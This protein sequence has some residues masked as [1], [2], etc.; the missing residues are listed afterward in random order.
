MRKEKETGFSL[1]V[2]STKERLMSQVSNT[3]EVG[4]QGPVALFIDPFGRPL[5]PVSPAGINRRAAAAIAPT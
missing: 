1:A 3:N 4:E 5:S 2:E